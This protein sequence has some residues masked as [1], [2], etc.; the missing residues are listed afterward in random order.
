MIPATDRLPEP[1]MS[2]VRSS[3]VALALAVVATALASFNADARRVGGGRGI[4][5]QRSAPAQPAAPPTT[6]PAPTTPAAPA[7]TPARPVPPGA[8]TPAPTPGRSWLGP[9]AGL[10]AGLGL[11][12]LMSHLGLGAEFGSLLLVAL[13]VFGGIWLLRAIVRRATTQAPLPAGA[14]SGALQAT[15]AP[16][17]GGPSFEAPNATRA[18]AAIEP[19]FGAALPGG[20]D[21]DGFARTAK[22]LFVRLQEANDAGRVEELRGFATP[23]LH[24]ALREDVVA[25]RGNPQRTDVV[26]LDAQVLDVATESAQQVVSV[27]FHGL[28]RETADLPAEPFDE[29]WHFVRPRDG[30]REW[31]VAG[32]QPAAELR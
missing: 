7:A 28:V 20:F 6:T 10:A 21:A 13:L 27:R 15:R 2:A 17:A 9:I 16:P 4:G 19:S 11:A 29:V 22:A 5:M 8:A 18:S 32:I 24:A 30:S 23:E 1:F 3:I 26:R 14:P 25:R 31:A 12:A